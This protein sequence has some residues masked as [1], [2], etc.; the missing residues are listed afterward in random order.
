MDGALLPV[1]VTVAV[2]GGVHLGAYYAAA[3]RLAGAAKALPIAVLLGWVLITPAVAE[4]Y[5]WLVAAGLAWSMSG[6]L[7]LLS[8]ARF[9]A[10]LTS[11]ALAHVC[12]TVAFGAASAVSPSP[13]VLALLAVAAG[14]LLGV[15]WP[16]LARERLP[17]ACYVVVIALMAWAAIGRA[18]APA[19]PHPSG[20]LA[21][22]GA[23]VF[24]ASDATLALDRFARSW[25]GA[26]AAVMVTYYTAQTLIAASV[27]A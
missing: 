2:A 22:W 11:F 5:R 14:G 19:T 25:R 6:D 1:A 21:A 16:N 10:G 9:R 15:L 13:C 17:V 27:A 18:A 23:V 26:H 4:P 7:L 3:L 12:Y 20:A 24:M 8:R